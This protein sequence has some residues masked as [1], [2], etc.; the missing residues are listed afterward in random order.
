MP[1][2]WLAGQTTRDQDKTMTCPE[3][4]ASCRKVGA[5]AGLWVMACT[6]CPRTWLRIVYADC[7]GGG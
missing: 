7:K 2:L 5:W 6:R 1:P 3:C 4:G